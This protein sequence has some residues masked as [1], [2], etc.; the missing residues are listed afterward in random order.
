MSKFIDVFVTLMCIVGEGQSKSGMGEG[1]KSP[2]LRK[3]KDIYINSFFK[4]ENF[5]S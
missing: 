2:I 5:V 4:K 1:D 3:I